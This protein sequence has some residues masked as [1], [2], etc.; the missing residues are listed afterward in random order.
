MQLLTWKLQITRILLA[1][2]FTLSAPLA[3]AETSLRVRLESEI[4]S[5]EAGKI[6]I[7]E[8]AEFLI[9]KTEESPEILDLLS[10][11]SVPKEK[12]ADASTSLFLKRLSLMIAKGKTDSVERLEMLSAKIIPESWSAERERI[13]SLVSSYLSLEK[14]RSDRDLDALLKVDFSGLPESS[15]KI[16]NDR[17]EE[18]VSE[19]VERAYDNDDV[20]QGF[21]S[22]SQVASLW[23]NIGAKDRA[24]QLL[25]KMSVDSLKAEQWTLDE[26]QVQNFVRELIAADPSHLK[27]FLRL[28]E[29]KTGKSLAQGDYNRARL[30]FNWV[31]GLRPDPS[32]ENTSFRKQLV[33]IGAEKGEN[34]FTN[35][36]IIELAKVDSFGF[37]DKLGLFFD[38]Y[39]GKSLPILIPSGFVVVFLALAY[40]LFRP[41]SGG[42][43]T[44]RSRRAK[45]GVKY[46]QVV[47]AD[48]EYTRL[49][50]VFGLK[51]SASE[52]QIKRAFRKAV[53]EHHPD[54]Y[55]AD[56]VVTDEEGNVD[57]TFQELRKTYNRI[58]EIRSSWFGSR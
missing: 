41:S 39:Y 23:P 49:L 45:K 43:S 40:F 9:L 30:Y 54:A 12:L 14:I 1:I 25:S 33:E 26:P 51:E 4:T 55:G 22:L 11:V 58:L 13:K 50:A 57:E 42:S 16:L 27:V 5:F 34:A 21:R 28:Y 6:S 37:S 8:L 15:R 7:D 20:F 29:W 18:V 56:G 47:E 38:G 48:D 19:F 52:S 31:I 53:K 36:R 3:F 24:E 44:S 32:P 10:E 2:I 46:S 17:L 35:Q